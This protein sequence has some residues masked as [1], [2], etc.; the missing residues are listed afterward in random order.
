MYLK[1]T[2][3]LCGWLLL[4]TFC[5]QDVLARTSKS[6]KVKTDSGLLVGRHLTT[7]NGRPIRAFMGIPYAQPP[8]GDLRFKVDKWL[9]VRIF[10]FAL[11]YT[12]G[13]DL[14]HITCSR[15]F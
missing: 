3:V 5:A 10:W 8:V 4:L 15:S 9:M 12:M 11:I 7:H 2:F 13:T 14:S 1:L 6:L